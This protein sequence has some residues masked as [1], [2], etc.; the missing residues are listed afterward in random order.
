MRSRR[1]LIGEFGIGF[2]IEERLADMDTYAVQYAHPSGMG[3]MGD[4]Q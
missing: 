3:G 1:S 4:T 2:A